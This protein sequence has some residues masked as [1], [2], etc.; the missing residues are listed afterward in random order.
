MTP[1]AHAAVGLVGWKFFSRRKDLKTLVFF[2]VAACALDADFLL[3]YLFGRPQVFVHQL[4]SHNICV[5]LAVALVFLPF[6]KT[7]RER[8]GLVF[9]SLTHLFMDLFVID[10]VA[11]VGFRLFFPVYNKFYNYGFFPFVQRGSA[12]ELFSV[13]NLVAVACEVAVFVVPALVLCRKELA[14]LRRKDAVPP[15]N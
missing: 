8:G 11:P 13:H 4:Y 3:Y 2:V 9:I 1:I 10:N 15:S 12:R 5:S 14:L 7:A 6:L